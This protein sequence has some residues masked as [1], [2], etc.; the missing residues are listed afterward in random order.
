MMSMDEKKLGVFSLT[1][2]VTGNMIGSGVFLLPST[3]ARLGSL[4]LVSWIITAMGSLFLAFV[5]SRLGR[6][7]PK[8]GGPYAYAQAGLGR[9]L[10]F[11]TAFCYWLAQF[12]RLSLERHPQFLHER[13]PSGCAG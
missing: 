3:M 2:L 6:F 13:L 1:A 9:E 7:M 8:T 5:F 12:S 11:Q 4:S 10:G